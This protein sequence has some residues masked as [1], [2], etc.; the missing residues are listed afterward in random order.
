M[1][2]EKILLVDDEAHIRDLARL[3][4]E[5]EGFQVRMATNGVEALARVSESP[6]ALVVLDLMMP[7]MDGWE[8]CRHLRATSNLPILMLT[9]RD[10]DIDKI[11]G[12]EM[13]AD[14]YLTKPFNPRELV[15]RVR[16]I[17]RRSAPGAGPGQDKARQV[18]DLMIDPASREATVNG[19]R[20]NLRAKEFDLLLTLV[21]HLNIVLSR[22]QLLDLVWGYE[23]YGQ[24]RTV[25]VH[26]AHLREKLGDC[27]V[28][29]ETVWGM[30]YKLVNG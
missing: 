11:V 2:G 17:L 25:D 5:K 12:L 3:Y 6:P 18:G 22:D 14:D 29:I 27:N 28:Q 21:D 4:L 9:A 15:A 24:T 16:A 13:G 19:E 7:E 8:V 1:A 20:L 26:I 30:G 23:F 10:D